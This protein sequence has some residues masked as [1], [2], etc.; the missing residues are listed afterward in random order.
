MMNPEEEC[1]L[2]DLV[3]LGK[4][5]FNVIQKMP[6]HSHF[7]GIMI[8]SLFHSGVD[9]SILMKPLNGSQHTKKEY[10]R[11]AALI[12]DDSNELYYTTSPPVTKRTHSVSISQESVLINFFLSNCKPEGNAYGTHLSRSSSESHLFHVFKYQRN[13]AGIGIKTFVQVEK[14]LHIVKSKHTEFDLF[15]CKSCHQFQ[16]MDVN[17]HPT[18]PEEKEIYL[19]YL[20]YKIHREK[21]VKQWNIYKNLLNSLKG[22]PKKCL[23]ILDFTKKFTHVKKAVIG[24][25]VVFRDRGTGDV[26]WN[27]LD[28]CGK[29]GT[30][31]A[32]NYFVQGMWESAFRL[33]VFSNIDQIDIFHDK[34]SNE[35]YNSSVLYI[36]SS[37]SAAHSCCVFHCHYFESCHGKSICDSH[38][39]QVTKKGNNLLHFLKPDKKYDHHFWY[40]FFCLSFHY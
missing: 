30:E 38:F 34:G 31:S 29:T 7:K 40:L 27:S 39:G 22:H 36:Y 17:K 12:G 3:E 8:S 35:L 28:F 9:R 32:D 2:S 16:N 20:N 4:G 25:F 10:I 15:F 33:G 18:T 11:K 1:N 13:S 19:K 5:V 37:L 23:V 21:V 14:A 26:T 6:P 24:S